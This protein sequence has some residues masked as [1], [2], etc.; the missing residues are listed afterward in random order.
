MTGTQTWREK[1]EATLQQKKANHVARK[2]ERAKEREKQR[3]NDPV[4]IL[5]QEKKEKLNKLYDEKKR[6]QER[7]HAHTIVTRLLVDKSTGKVNGAALDSHVVI[8]FTA[9]GYAFLEKRR[10]PVGA[11]KAVGLAEFYDTDDY[12]LVGMEH[13]TDISDK[14]KSLGRA[15]TGGLFFGPTGA[16]IGAAAAKNK[17][18]DQSQMVFLLQN[19]RTKDLTEYLVPCT[20]TEFIN[21]YR[22]IP[23]NPLLGQKERTGE[24][25]VSVADE[26]L[27]LKSLMEDGLLTQE[28]FIAMKEKILEKA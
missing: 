20:K 7:V 25:T 14:G 1:L 28:E 6:W 8:T 15:V 2:E 26:L 24:E 22:S 16:I 9:N 21:T 5:Q 18:I 11:V 3:E 17:I 27:K 10:T 13:L 23:V 12:C 19:V 4:F